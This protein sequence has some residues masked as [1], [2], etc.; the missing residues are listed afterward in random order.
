[1]ELAALLCALCWLEKELLCARAGGGARDVAA[2][3][4]DCMA[5]SSY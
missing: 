3:A 4:W 2:P 5:A 1:V